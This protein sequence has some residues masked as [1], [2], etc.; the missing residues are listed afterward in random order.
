MFQGKELLFAIADFQII[1]FRT[2]CDLVNRNN[3]A[4]LLV[5]RVSVQ[6][7]FVASAYTYHH[8]PVWF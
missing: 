7:A 4:P 3:F 6:A 5:S 2:V 8:H 1:S